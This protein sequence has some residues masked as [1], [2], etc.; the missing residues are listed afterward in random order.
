MKRKVKVDIDENSISGNTEDI[1]ELMEEAIK[2]ELEI[3]SA[4]LDGD[5][6]NYSYEL[7]TGVCTGDCLSRDGASIV[8]DDLKEKFKRLSVHIAYL[9]DSYTLAGEEV[10][11][12]DACH[13]DDI[14]TKYEAVGFKLDGTG[15]NESVILSGIKSVWFGSIKIK[16]PKITF[17][18]SYK[19]INELR[20]SVDECIEEVESYMN[21]KTAPKLIQTEME[22]PN[23]ENQ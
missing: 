3:K 22:F 4:H 21:G 5:F 20:V 7:K 2:K 19:F 10:G 16:M 14:A 15:E 8:H 18:G 13:E 17:D 6:C 23:E 1:L 9:D 12:I 11:D